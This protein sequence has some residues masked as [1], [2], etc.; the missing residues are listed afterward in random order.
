[1]ELEAPFDPAEPHLHG[2]HVLVVAGQNLHD[3]G[4]HLAQRANPSSVLSSFWSAAFSLSSERW[5]R[6]Y[7]NSRMPASSTMRFCSTPPPA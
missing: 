5:K 3:A 2:Q 1:V 4:H 6:S 7:T